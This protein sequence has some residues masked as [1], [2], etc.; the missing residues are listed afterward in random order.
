MEN[1]GVKD[2][3][4][5]NKEHD[6]DKV[7]GRTPNGSGA[8]FDGCVRGFITLH[9]LLSL[10]APVTPPPFAPPSLQSLSSRTHQTCSLPSLLRTS[11]RRHSMC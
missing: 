9:V 2:A 5:K 3:S 10:T 8:Y 11:Q 7:M 4:D 6:G 1:G